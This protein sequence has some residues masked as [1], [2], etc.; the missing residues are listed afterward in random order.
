MSRLRWI[1]TVLP[2]RAIIVG[3]AR[4]T[5]VGVWMRMWRG[6]WGGVGGWCGMRVGMGVGMD[7][8]I[9]ALFQETHAVAGTTVGHP[10]V[11]MLTPTFPPTVFHFPIRVTIPDQKNGMIQAGIATIVPDTRAVSIQMICVNSY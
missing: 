7:L 3:G 5:G 9:S 6:A 1:I 11:A 10:D 4:G 2:G 8:D